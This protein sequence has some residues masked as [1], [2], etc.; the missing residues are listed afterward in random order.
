M[1]SQPPS[2][3][4]SPPHPPPQTQTQTTYNQATWIPL[5]IP[6]SALMPGLYNIN[7]EEGFTEDQDLIEKFATK[8]VKKDEFGL[9]FDD[10]ISYSF[11]TQFKILHRHDLGR[12]KACNEVY[13]NR[14]NSSKNK[15]AQGIKERK[16]HVAH[17][18][19][20][21]AAA[22]AAMNTSMGVG[23][24]DDVSVGDAGG[25]NS[26]NPSPTKKSYK[27][28]KTRHHQRLRQ[29]RGHGHVDTTKLAAA[30]AVV[31]AGLVKGGAGELVI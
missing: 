22:A 25:S 19:T 9:G 7:I 18:G 3:C 1:S 23:D 14:L 27:V 11:Y 26:P 31:V 2:T 13:F 30:A 6:L 21:T 20:A 10:Q 8:K 12:A 4:P 5:S 29:G 17:Q 24:V 28:S 15:I 16:G